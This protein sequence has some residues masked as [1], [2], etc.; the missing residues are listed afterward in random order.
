M[1][2][3]K[4][5]TIRKILEIIP[6]KDA[7]FIELVRVDGWKSVVKKNDFKVGDYGVYFEYDSFLPIEERFEF[8]RKS[9]FRKMFVEGKGWIEGF[10]LRT[11]KLKN[12]ISQGLTMPLINFP[13]INI[14]IDINLDLSEKLGVLKYEKP[15]PLEMSGDIMGEIPSIIRKTDQE[16]IQNLIEYFE[17]YKNVEFE[18]TEKEDGMSSTM[19]F[20]N[21]HFGVC[22][23]NWEFKENPDQTMWKLAYKHNLKEVMRIMKAEVAIQGEIVGEGIQKNPMVLKGHYFHIFDIYD[24][25]KGRYMLP[26][27]RCDYINI[28]N[29]I[30]LIPLIHVPIINSNIKIFNI[31]RTIEDILEYVKGDT[32]YCKGCKREGLVFKST[33]LINDNIVSFKVID[34]NVAL[35]DD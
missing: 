3:R 4:L 7:D 34:N 1:S 27:E 12:Q 22:G 11:I 24:I 9:C 30:V 29:T 19:Y 35:N 6:I 16:R 25:K 31:C 23:H 8:L 13:E 15:I 26:K 10:R 5:V 18:E 21:N 17:I 20:Y 14:N 32:K 2:I 33:E 28:A